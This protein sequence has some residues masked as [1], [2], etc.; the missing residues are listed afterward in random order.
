M[1]KT[2]SNARSSLGHFQRPAVLTREAANNADKCHDLAF[3]IK[4][5]PFIGIPW[6]CL[7]LNRKMLKHIDIA[8]TS[9][10]M[11]EPYK[12]LSGKSP[13]PLRNKG[14]I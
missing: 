12:I 8:L 6:H 10:H 11:M 7:F 3:G 13:G 4:E 14:D 1:K 5:D 2:C 9:E